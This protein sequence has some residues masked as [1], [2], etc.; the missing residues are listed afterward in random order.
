MDELLISIIVPVYNVEQYVRECLDSIKKQ[1]YKRLEVIIVNDG[2]TDGSASICRE[3]CDKDNRFILVEQIN[4]GLSAARNT[5]MRYIHGDFF[6]FVDSD[7]FLD[8]DL[9]NHMVRFAQDSKCDII[10]CGTSYDYQD[11]MTKETPKKDACVTKRE[12]INKCFRQENGLLHTAWGK[13]YSKKLKH[14]ITYPVGRLYED[15]FVTYKLLLRST[16]GVI[17]HDAYHYRIR[18][19]SIKKKKKNLDRKT[20]DFMDS[21]IELK[22]TFSNEDPELQDDFQFKLALDSLDLLQF[23]AIKKY[24]NSTYDFAIQNL[25]R[26]DNKHILKYKGRRAFRTKLLLAKYFPRFFCTVYKRCKLI[27]GRFVNG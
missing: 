2:S 6:M 11:H 23:N 13:L 8:E 14:F 9:L 10:L 5:G 24:M 18:N 1:T 17:S 19:G 12:I 7:D 16:C 27:Q 25:R 4:Q 3:F 15:Q 22:N 21:I 26:I 20:I